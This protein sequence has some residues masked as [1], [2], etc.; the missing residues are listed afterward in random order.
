MASNISITFS[1]DDVFQFLDALCG[2][3]NENEKIA[4][5]DLKFQGEMLLSNRKKEIIVPTYEEWLGLNLLERDG[6]IRRKKGT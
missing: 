5:A 1:L 4:D 2:H 6:E 3:Q